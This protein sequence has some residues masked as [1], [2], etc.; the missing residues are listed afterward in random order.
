MRFRYPLI[1]LFT[2]ALGGVFVYGAS[3]RPPRV[4][5]N[6]FPPRPTLWPSPTA[7]SASVR[8]HVTGPVNEPGVYTLPTNALVR[9]ALQA[10][11]GPTT[12]ADLEK[13]NL[14]AAVGD[15]EQ[16]VVPR[17]TPL[18]TPT[19][20]SPRAD[21]EFQI[22]NINTADSQ[23]LE[24]LPRIGPVLA[25]RIIEYR[26]QHGPFSDVSELI[27]VKGIGEVTLEQLRPYITVMP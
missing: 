20:D 18:T 4:V 7:T 8:C 3:H 23:T 13:I 26:E 10:A 6:V 5:I 12:D 14:A 9:D 2:I 25:L 16:I 1:A 15:H 24:T 21:P 17:R 11:G 19:T 22:V 27:E